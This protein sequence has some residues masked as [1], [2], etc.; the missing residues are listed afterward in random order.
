[1]VNKL[2]IGFYLLLL[3]S[4]CTSCNDEYHGKIEEHLNLVNKTKSDV[5]IK[6]GFVKKNLLNMDSL[7]LNDP[8]N[9]AYNRF[10]IE[11]NIVNTVRLDS[12]FNEFTY[13]FESDDIQ[14][15]W[16]SEKEFNQYVSQLKIYKIINNDT[17]YANPETYNQKSD[18]EYSLFYSGGGILISTPTTLSNVFNY[19]TITDNMFAQ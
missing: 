9:Q 11:N 12:V 4:S 8:N 17:I 3:L 7:S 10:F 5:Y 13:Y 15:I 14:N 1:M 6:F 2:K 18:W 16:M 19:L